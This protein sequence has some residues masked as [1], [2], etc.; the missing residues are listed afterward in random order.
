MVAQRDAGHAMGGD[1]RGHLVIVAGIGCRQGTTMAQLSAALAAALAA[2][3]HDRACLTAL[4]AP[5]RKDHEPAL[6]KFAKTL[7]LPLHLIADDA[8]L[9][10][11]SDAADSFAR[12]GS[13]SRDTSL[14]G[15]SCSISCSRA[16]LAPNRAARGQWS[17]HLRACGGAAMTVYF[18][19]AGPGAPDLLT[20]RGRDLLARCPVCLYAGSLVPRE[21]WRIAR[22]RRASSTPR[23]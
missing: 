17:R 10:R 21:I 13:P 8:L 14:T 7:G 3:G 18:I 12:S 15:R 19:G 16:R 20:L 6:L 2:G 1:E 9:A 4:A 5:T 11:S 23:Q 22:R